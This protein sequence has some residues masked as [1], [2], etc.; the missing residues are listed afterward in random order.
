MWHTITNTGLSGH[1]D[2]VLTWTWKHDTE[3]LL[4]IYPCYRS[5]LGSQLSTVDSPKK[6]R[7]LILA[8][9]LAWRSYWTNGRVAWHLRRHDMTPVWRHCMSHRCLRYNPKLI[10]A[11]IHLGLDNGLSPVRRQAII[12][13]NAGL[14]SIRPLG[15]NFGR[16]LIGILTF[17]KKMSSV[18]WRPFRIGL[19][20]KMH[21]EMSPV[22]WGLFRLVLQYVWQKMRLQDTVCYVFHFGRN[23]WVMCFWFW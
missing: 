10:E 12:W 17:I 8:L 14:L 5:F 23:T 22:R 11:E 21:L 7:A 16:I 3:K 9:L 4:L 1:H 13:T 6:D 20:K 19:I 15:T 2:G 18:K